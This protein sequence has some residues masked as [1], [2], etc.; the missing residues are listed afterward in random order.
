MKKYIAL[1]SIFLMGATYSLTTIDYPVFIN[2]QQLA[3]TD[4]VPMNYQG[5]TMLPL[6]AVS[7]ALDIPI[8]WN[9]AERRVDIDTI[10]IEALKESCVMIYAYNS[11][12]GV[13]GSG[14]YI[15]YDQVL[16]AYHVIDEGTNIMTS[17]GVKLTV[18]DTNST[19]DAAVLSTAVEVKPVKIGDSDEVEVGDK[20]ILITSPNGEKNTV[21]YG[22]VLE[23]DPIGAGQ[24]FIWAGVG[25]G[26]SG[27]ACFNMQGELIGIVSNGSKTD[28]ANFVI[29]INDIRQAL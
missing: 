22:K 28:K 13:Q 6:R 10:D 1:F 7:E 11:T 26:A 18:E 15:D 14:V 29:P 27:G 23:L 17:D 5:R 25:G 16:T 24:I 12:D 3:F 2:G 4:A 19:L 21:T 9:E 8:E 20:V